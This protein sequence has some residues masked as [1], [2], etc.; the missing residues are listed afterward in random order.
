MRKKNSLPQ[1]SVIIRAYNAS[2]FVRKAIESVF[3]QT[4]N[5]KIYEIVVVDDGSTDETEKILSSYEDKIKLIRQKHK[6]HI[7]ALNTGIIQARGAYVILLDSD[8]LFKPEILKKMLDVFENEKDI[9]FVYCDY[10]EKDMTSGKQKIVSLRDNVF[11]SVAVGIM[12]RKRILEETGLYDENLIF[13]EYDLLIKAQKKYKSA[14]ISQPLFIYQRH[15]ASITAN[16]EKVRIGKEQLFAKY[17]F[18]KGLRSY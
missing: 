4:I 8:D 14:Y 5:P 16:K 13:P 6:G 3:R 11:N 17:G 10:Y 15:G 2:R 18:I 7:R 1:I 9:D 12:F